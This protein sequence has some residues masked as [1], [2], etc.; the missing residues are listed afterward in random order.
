MKAQ[1]NRN[2]VKFLVKQSAEM[3]RAADCSTH[4]EL[5]QRMSDLQVMNTCTVLPHP[6]CPETERRTAIRQTLC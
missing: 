3:V 6:V 4:G 5:Q 2:V 1:L